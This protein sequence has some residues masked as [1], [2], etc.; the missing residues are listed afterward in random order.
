MSHH[1]HVA[2]PASRLMKIATLAAVAVS[3]MLVLIKLYA[4][5]VTGSVSIMSSLI[6]SF[7][8]MGISIM[9]FVAVRYALKPP[10]AEHRFGHSG[11]EDIAALIQAAFIGGSALF[12]A[13]AS[14]EY[15]I[16]PQHVTETTVGLTVMGISVLAT[17]A[18]VAF[19]QYAIRHTRSTVVAADSLH[20]I[21]DLFMNL[22][23]MAGIWCSH[24]YG[25]VYI[26]P[27]LAILVALYI[28]YGAWE[29]GQHAIDKLMDKEFPDAERATVKA[30]I[31]AYPGVLGVHAL[32]TRYSGIKP[33][34]QFHLELDGTQSLH[35]AHH[36]A[37]GVEHHLMELFPGAE[38]VVHQDPVENSS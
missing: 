3:A 25:W 11:A 27:I 38:V 12:I 10:D 31:I 21:G 8:D 20:Y 15:F 35:D 34:I 37:D 30:A 16:T 36:I 23:I 5:I 29:I 1:H 32:K 22:A 18:L 17:G 14:I 9:N 4:W 28:A 7:L 19:Q 24:A 2:L 6:D 33:F 13:V 26:D